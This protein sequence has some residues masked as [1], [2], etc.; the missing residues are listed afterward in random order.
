MLNRVELLSIVALSDLN[1]LPTLTKCALFHQL[2]ELEYLSFVYG[3]NCNM[4]L[5]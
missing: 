5:F 2:F 1:T 3:F 4:A